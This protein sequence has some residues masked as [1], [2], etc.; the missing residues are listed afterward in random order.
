MLNGL[1][2]HIKDC[3][4]CLFYV[5][6]IVCIIVRNAVPLNRV[7][8]VRRSPIESEVKYYISA[9]SWRSVLQVE[10]TGVHGG[11]IDLP[12]VTD[13]FII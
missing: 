6:Y 10:D 3:L 5:G 9:I 4:W 7:G 13:N 2:F 8:R 11:T 1:I 12:Q